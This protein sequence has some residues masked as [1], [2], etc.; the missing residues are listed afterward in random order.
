MNSADFA[1]SRYDPIVVDSWQFIIIDREVGLPFELFDIVEDVLLMLSDDPSQ[2]ELVERTI[3]DVIPSAAQESFYRDA[4]IKR[5]KEFHRPAP[6]EVQYEGNRQ[7]SHDP[8]RQILLAHQTKMSG[9]K[10]SREANRFIRRVIDDME[11]CGVVSIAEE[12]DRPQTRP[13]IIQGSDG[14]LDLYFPYEFSGLSPEVE[15]TPNLSLPRKTCLLDFV[16][17]FKDQHPKGIV[18]KG[19]ILPHY[20]AWPIPAF[21]RTGKSRL[22]FGTW[23]GHVYHWNA[24]RKRLSLM[25]SP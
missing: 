12:Y 4:K 18:A 22:N 21:R 9:D 23:E 11:R 6:P 25:P 19:T 3:Q 13:V 15:L 14:G 2:S 5:S 10:T 7:R 20:C 1:L 17:R 16:R 8:D 24:M